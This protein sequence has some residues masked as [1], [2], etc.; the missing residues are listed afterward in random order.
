MASLEGHITSSNRNKSLKTLFLCVLQL[1][2]D[3]RKFLSH[4]WC[5][6]AIVAGMPVVSWRL[7][8]GMPVMPCCHMEL[9]HIRQVQRCA[10]RF[11]AE[12]EF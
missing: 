5:H 3:S 2:S 11:Q 4:L 7:I 6:G 12:S 9:C 8:A 1:M 10:A